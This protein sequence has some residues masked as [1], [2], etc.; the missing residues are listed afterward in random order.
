[1]PTVLREGGYQ[2]IIFTSDHP[3]A[4]VHIRHSDRLAKL[5]LNPIQFERNGGFKLNEQ[6]R[7]LEIVEANYAILI[8]AWDDLYPSQEMP[9]DES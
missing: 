8:A 6:R 5:R 1:M 7:I 2:F 3:P 9:E 4:H